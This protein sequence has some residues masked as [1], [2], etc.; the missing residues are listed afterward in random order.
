MC[1]I[2]G[3]LS[4]ADNLKERSDVI[5]AMTRTLA[6]R[7]PDG[8]GVWTDRHVALGHRRLAVIDLAGGAQPMVAR[9]DDGSCVSLSYNGELYNFRELRQELIGLGHRFTSDSDTEVLLRAYLEWGEAVTDHLVG[10]FAF[11]LWDG[12]KQSLLLARDFLGVKPLF[13]YPTGDGVVF[14]SEPKAIFAHPDV[15]PCIDLDG[16]R[17]ILLLTRTPGRSPY[18][19]MREVKPGHQLRFSR[20]GVHEHRFWSLQAHEHEDDLDTTIARVRELLA[21]AVDKQLVSDVPICTL[22]SGGLDSS[23]ITALAQGTTTQQGERLRSFSVDFVQGAT[24]QFAANGPHKSSDTPFV[25][26]FV[27]HSQCDHR[28]IILDSESLADPELNRIVMRASD[29]PASLSGDMCASLYCLFKAIRG[30]STVALSGEAADE[31]FGGYAWFFDRYSVDAPRFPWLSTTGGVFNGEQVISRALRQELRLSEFHQQ[32]YEEAVSEAPTLPGESAEDQRMRVMNYLH[33]T[34]FLQFMLDRKDRMSMAVGLEVRVPFCDPALVDYV[35]NV[36]WSMKR[37]D[38]REKSILRA[39]V[40][41]LLPKGI[42]ERQKSPYPATQDPRYEQALRTRVGD[43][44]DQPSHPASPLFNRKHVERLLRR[45]MRDEHSLHYERADL[46]R[47]VSLS[48]WIDDYDV[49]LQLA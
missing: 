14:G 48:N 12:R 27:A 21:N 45:P 15:T 16:M 34:R 26:E 42:L 3:W 7:G 23:A 25:R 36:P 46:E 41:D 18:R 22:L 11:A 17:E 30:A 8:E 24:Q 35:F 44:L 19:G 31:I 33:L 40:S 20:E 49:S 6:A 10:M 13:Y 37:F 38:G 32:C 1:G 2:A 39:A 43:L 47:V 29:L 4:F 9:R 5:E 28:E